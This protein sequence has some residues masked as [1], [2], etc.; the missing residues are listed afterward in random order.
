MMAT[1]ADRFYA[2]AQNDAKRIAAAKKVPRSEKRK[3]IS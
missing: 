1:E 3:L 2:S